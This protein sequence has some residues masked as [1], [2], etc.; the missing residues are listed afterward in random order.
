M[1]IATRA[2]ATRTDRE[3]FTR[4]AEARERVVVVPSCTR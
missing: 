3:H 2:L 1:D 4:T